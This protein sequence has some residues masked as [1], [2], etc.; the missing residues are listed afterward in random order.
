[1]SKSETLSYAGQYNLIQAD[2]LQPGGFA[3]DIRDQIQLITVYEDLYSPLLSGNL[4]MLDTADLPNLFGQ[5]GSDLF[6][7]K[8]KTPSMDK[9]YTIDRLFHIYRLSDREQVNE[10]SQ[11]YVYHFVAVESLLD[12][13][14]TISKTFRGRA[15]EIVQKIMKTSINTDIKINV[16]TTTNEFTYTSNHWAP[17]KNIVYCSSNAIAEKTKTPD[18]IFFE[19][20]DGL[21]FKSLTGLCKEEPI[22]YFTSDNS[23]SQIEGEGVNAGDVVKNLE[24]DYRNISLVL[25]NN[26]YDYIKTKSR[27][28]FSTR[29]FSYDM[30]SKDITDT[31]YNTNKDKRAK[32]NTAP[33]YK[34][35]LIDNSYLGANS[36]IMLNQSH[37]YK[38]YDETKEVSDF[39]VKQQ[40]ISIL[41]QMQFQKIEITVFGRTDYTVGKTVKVDINSLRQF[42]KTV[43]DSDI[44]DN[45]LSG[46]YLISA[47]AHRFNRE[48]KHECTLE[49]SRDSVREKK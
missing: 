36:T 49:L 24:V 32:L 35:T 45:M 28:A 19:N 44:F 15:E 9:Q 41:Q 25:A 27:G 2:V 17:F 40:R 23:L 18:L 5:A 13:N 26:Y 39:E 37:H 38:L 8:I 42:D 30:T 48:G 12:S 33:F 7:L 34:P 3:L 21:N 22:M 43:P 20:R 10:R 11:T 46:K 6:R 4:V 31:T 47:V 29:M 16:D 14:T 1:M